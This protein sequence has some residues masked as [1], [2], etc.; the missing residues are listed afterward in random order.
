[1][2]VFWKNIGIC[3]QVYMAPNPRRRMSSATLIV[4]NVTIVFG[5][6]FRLL[7]SQLLYVEKAGYAAKFRHIHFKG[8]KKLNY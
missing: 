4:E 6:S 2:P 1:M 5:A 8:C 7:I 3:L